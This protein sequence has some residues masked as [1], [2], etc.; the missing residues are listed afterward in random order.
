MTLA[1]ALVLLAAA[2]LGIPGLFVAVKGLA[3]IR[4][5]SVLMQGRTVTGARAILA[6]LILL[7]WGVGMMGFAALVLVSQAPR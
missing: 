6:G 2:L 5:R 7:G 4:R 3:A 1:R